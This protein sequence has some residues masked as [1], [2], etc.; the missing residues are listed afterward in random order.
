MNDKIQVIFEQDEIG[1]CT[2]CRKRKAKLY[3]LA[4][5]TGKG[6]CVNLRHCESCEFTH[7]AFGADFSEDEGWLNRG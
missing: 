4:Y 6:R 1:Y 7:F 5:V 3:W 2:N